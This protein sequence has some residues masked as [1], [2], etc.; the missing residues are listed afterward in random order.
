MAG[1][2]IRLERMM[3]QGGL[4]LAALAL[5]QSL[6][7]VAGQW[8]L[9]V[10]GLGAAAALIGT[11]APA[12]T[13]VAFRLA[14]V[15]AM[16]C[17]MLA[18]TPLL[19]V[20]GRDMSDHLYH[21]QP[22]RVPQL[23]AAL[24]AL[25]APLAALLCA[26]ALPLLGYDG[27]TGILSAIVA[28]AAL[29]AVLWSLTAQA[30]ALDRFGLA[31]GAL[32]LGA[33]AGLGGTLAAAQ[34]GAGMAGLLWAYGGGVALSACGLAR[35]LARTFPF[36][37]GPLGPALRH[38]ASRIVAHRALAA[39]G[40]LGA[41]GLWIDKLILWHVPRAQVSSIGLRYLAPYD[42][43]VFLGLL[44]LIPGLA[45]LIVTV[46]V[47]LF[48]RLHRWMADLQAHATLNEINHGAS[49]LARD[50]AS[51]VRRILIVQAVVAFG[52]CVVAARLGQAGWIGPLQ[53]PV[54]AFTA[55]GTVFYLSALASGIVLL[56]LDLARRYLAVQAV[57]FVATAVATVAF[58]ALGPRFLGL[59]FPAGALAAAAV[60]AVL[61]GEALAELPRQ[62]FRRAA[63]RR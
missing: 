20:A 48:A 28:L 41:A 30:T 10:L 53:I 43:A 31:A 25:A 40:L 11:F 63:A 58:Q 44:V 3:R 56:H 7:L 13:V 52:G 12:E 14:V 9:G 38:L 2:G 6:L 36:D 60:G 51:D 47:R 55:I 34:A 18:A 62:V 39:G 49:D 24:V 1:I 26:A 17:A 29:H 57:F 15:V 23:L 35:A 5:G 21:R 50:T 54:M 37:P 19:L 22:G 4:S 8:M 61:A 46:E 32:C 42:G 59:G 27:G 45:L 33:T 16:L